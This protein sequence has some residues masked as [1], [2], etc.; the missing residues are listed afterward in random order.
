MKQL[1]NL[2]KGILKYEQHI[3][4]ALQKDLGKNP[5]ETYVTEIGFVLNSIRET[6]K[7]IPEWAKDKKVSTPF[8]LFPSKSKRH[9]EPY[10]TVLIIGP[11]NYPFQLL[12]EPLIGAISAGNTIILKPSEKKS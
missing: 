4:A 8:F 12:I 6:K 1:E 2:K 7:K 3:T 9:Y 5:V 11:F 10:G